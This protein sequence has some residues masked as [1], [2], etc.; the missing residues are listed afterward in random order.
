V[1]NQHSIIEHRA[2]YFFIPLQDDYLAI[3]GRVNAEI[4]RIE[5]RT[6]SG[7]A[8]CKGMILSVLEG[9]M[10]SKRPSASSED[11][12]YVYF[13]Y[14]EWELQLR[15]RYMRSTIIRC[16]DE[17]AQEG[18]WLDEQGDIH[19]GLIKRKPHVQNTYAYVLNIQVLQSLLAQLPEQS[20]FAPRPRT[21][22]GRPK[23]NR[24]KINGI[25]SDGIKINGL[26]TDDITEISSENGR[27]NDEKSSENTRNNAKY[28]VKTN[29][30]FY[31][32]NSNT[33]ITKNT[34]VQETQIEESAARA[35][36][37]PRTASQEKLEAVSPLVSPKSRI[38]PA[39]KK[40]DLFESASP[41]AQAIILEW[42][43]CHKKQIAVTDTLVKHAETLKEYEPEVGEIAACVKWMWATNREWYESK[44]LH[45]GNVVSVFER[46]RSL[47]DVPARSEP[48]RK[49]VPPPE[50]DAV[51]QEKLARAQ[52][53]LAGL[54]A[55]QPVGMGV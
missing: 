30:P 10:N 37:T 12:L 3:C 7:P 39:R 5:G 2:N 33:Q 15:Y 44:G 42:K 22:L 51:K 6:S 46:F 54:R 24:S 43:S 23:K 28:R 9:W 40:P 18:Q 41:G 14:D 26:K 48:T 53:A 47:A 49:Q 38:Q 16:L 52:A 45:M 8:D 20:P 21:P 50:S 27:I 34:D 36:T 1:S 19:V 35:D 31:T 55:A 29:A 13:T 32:Q 17:M 11:D 25:N 4:E